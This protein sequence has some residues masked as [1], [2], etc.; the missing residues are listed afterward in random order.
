[1]LAAVRQT[2]CWGRVIAVGWGGCT[3]VSSVCPLLTEPP[4]FS[5]LAAAERVYH[6]G[7]LKYHVSAAAKRTA[8]LGLSADELH[9]TY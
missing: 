9:D 7:Q 2:K 6:A 3:T 5:P 4:C 8:G 1:M